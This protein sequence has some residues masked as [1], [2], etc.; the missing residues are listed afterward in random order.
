VTRP[1]DVESLARVLHA[2]GKEAVE[3]GA[4]VN[5][6]PGQPFLEWDE[7]PTHAQEG[8][9]IQA[10]YLLERGMVF[11]PHPWDAFLK[12][13]LRAIDW[14]SEDGQSAEYIVHALSLDPGQL[15]LLLMTIASHKAEGVW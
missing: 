7:L 5:R 6:V 8:R 10:R 13:R 11:D 12:A 14:M 15:Q 3:K 2:A 4:V 9:R 1:A